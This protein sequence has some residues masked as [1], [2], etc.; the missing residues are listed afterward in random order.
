MRKNGE[1][2]K[3]SEKR[4]REERMWFDLDYTG[5]LIRIK[6][7]SIQRWFIIKD[8]PTAIV[9]F[10]NHLIAKTHSYAA[11]FDL[12]KLSLARLSLEYFLLFIYCFSHAAL[13]NKLTRNDWKVDFTPVLF[14]TTKIVDSAFEKKNEKNCSSRLPFF[15]FLTSNW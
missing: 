5:K 15:L 11:A 3:L 13:L 1:I 12:I 6:C 9:K 7:S 2:M 14:T 10:S 8:A 4:R